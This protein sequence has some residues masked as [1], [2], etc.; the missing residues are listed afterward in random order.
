[1]QRK[2]VL[3]ANDTSAVDEVIDGALIGGAL[4][5]AHAAGTALAVTGCALGLAAIE[6]IVETC[7]T[8]LGVEAGEASACMFVQWGLWSGGIGASALTAL[9]L[10]LDMLVVYC[11]HALGVPEIS[12]NAVVEVIAKV[13]LSGAAAGAGYSA[14][15]FFTNRDNQAEDKPE[16]YLDPNRD[17]P[18]SAR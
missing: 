16:R 4:G 15:R 2:R 12:D 18:C 17:R 9:N 6:P 14:L 8:A 5:A 3:A 1:M 7:E 10:T 13:A 11:T